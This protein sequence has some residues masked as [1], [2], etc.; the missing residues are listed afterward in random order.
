MK[1]THLQLLLFLFFIGINSFSQSNSSSNQELEKINELNNYIQWTTNYA[2][3]KKIDSANKYAKRAWELSEK[4]NDDILK[5]R[6]I[7]TNAII[8]YWQTKTEDAKLLLSQNTENETL[9]DSLT[10]KSIRLMGEI[11]LYEENFSEA[12]NQYLKVEKKVRNKGINSW[13]DSLLLYKTY[14]SIGLVQS[15][16]KNIENAVSYFNKAKN[17]SGSRPE[18][19]NNISFYKASV[20]EEENN[21]RESIKYSLEGVEISKKNNFD[22]WLPSYYKSISSSYLK[23]GIADSAIYYSKKGL[24]NN[25]DCQLEFLYNNLGKGYEIKGEP[26]KA[27]FNYH[28]ALAY[29][30]EIEALKI[31]ENMRDSYIKLK[32]YKKALYHNQ[33]YLTLKKHVD[34]LEIR[35]QLKEITEKYESEK[36]RL[37]IKILQSKDKYNDVVI[38]RKNTQIILITSVLFG[39]FTLLV[40]ILIS[41]KKQKKQKNILFVKNRELAKRIKNGSNTIFDKTSQI[42]NSD[43]KIEAQNIDSEQRA[44][45]HEY[46]EKAIEEEF[47]LDKNISLAE[48]AKQANTNTTYMSK[49]IN[50]DFNK[51]FA[52][53]INELRIS[54]TLK[55]LEI[56]P[57]Y[58]KLTIDNIS[59]KAGFTSN[60]AFYNAFKKFTGLT[61]SYYVKKA[62]KC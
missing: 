35:Q 61:P 32:D 57:K 17:Y 7:Y 36:N 31:H 19:E 16:V 5:A 38:K 40:V 58:R 10:Y 39:S 27:I 46:I 28:K 24:E 15:K 42:N 47:Y 21:L 18:L 51:S 62:L 9:P 56:S 1:V 4:L 25:K 11:F 29:S 44:K 2:S 26:K 14:L 37:E 13:N 54:Y 20:F 59:D 49:I 55:K 48:F 50:E 52:I 53:F 60:S 30:S 3:Q 45:I 23:L 22:V 6:V 12:L 8:L 33:K 43:K 34:S 41:Y